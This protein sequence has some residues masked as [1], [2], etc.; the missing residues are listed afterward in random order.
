MTTTTMT[1]ITTTITIATTITFCF[2]QT[3]VS[4]QI[5]FVALRR[6][7]LCIF[8]SS[9]VARVVVVVVVVGVVVVVVVRV[10]SILR[11]SGWTSRGRAQSMG[12]PLVCS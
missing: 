4:C 10:G 3:M 8:A 12:A 9:D 11:V 5:P 1:T 7:R 2:L 6:G